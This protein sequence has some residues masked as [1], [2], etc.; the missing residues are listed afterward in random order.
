[1]YF[2]RNFC[3]FNEFLPLKE[4]S[5][6]FVIFIFPYWECYSMSRVMGHARPR[7]CPEQ[8]CVVRAT[9]EC[10]QKRVRGP[11]NV[12][13]CQGDRYKTL[14]LTAVQFGYHPKKKKKVRGLL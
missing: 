2:W 12:R 6:L 14:L 8:I 4:R 10:Q 1:M 3:S 7:V 11:A 13:A 9:T 5:P